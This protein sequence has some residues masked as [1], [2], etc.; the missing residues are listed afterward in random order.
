[1]DTEVQ[2]AENST[3]SQMCKC[4][5]MENYSVQKETLSLIRNMLDNVL[6]TITNAPLI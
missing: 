3:N 5:H 4:M 2:S 1:M 6:E